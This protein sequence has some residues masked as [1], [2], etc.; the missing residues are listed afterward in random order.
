MVM[1]LTE[2]TMDFLYGEQ[3]AGS[4][5]YTD[6]FKCYLH[7]LNTPKGY[8]LSLKSPEDHQHHKGLS[9]G[10]RT[11]GVNFWE[12]YSTRADEVVGQQQHTTFASTVFQGDQVGFTESVAW[13]AEHGMLVFLEQ[14]TIH[15][16]MDAGQFIWTW[17]SDLQA[18]Q[19]L[20]LTISQ[21]SKSARSGQMVNYHGLGL[22][23]S[24]DFVSARRKELHLDGRPFSFPD[25]LGEQPGEV[26]LVASTDGTEPVRGAGVALSVEPR[27]GLFVMDDPF[28][29]LSLGPTVL[30]GYDLKAGQ[31]IRNEFL[32]RVF[33]LE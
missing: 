33:D 5:C 16:A 7:P 22:R 11:Q 14:R 10:L 15:C 9:Y 30:G 13:K 1:R 27:T 24:W 31:H 26:Q 23:F 8:T 32:I 17:L 4:Y 21:W 19:D 3:L 20:T 28:V 18:Q 12:E 25:A 2:H 29:F 6:P